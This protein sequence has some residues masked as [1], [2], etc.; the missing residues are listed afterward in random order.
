M[1]YSSC[2]SYP[3]AEFVVG[4]WYTRQRPRMAAGTVAVGIEICKNPA[5]GI[6]Y[7]QKGETSFHT[8]QRKTCKMVIS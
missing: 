6:Y 3:P 8:V 5:A 7:C 4:G 1:S 2:S